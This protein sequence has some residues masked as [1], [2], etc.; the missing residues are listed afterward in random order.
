V[1]TTKQFQKK[2]K[3]VEVKLTPDQHEMVIRRAEK[4]GI[5]LATWMRVVLMQVARSQ[6]ANDGYIRIREPDRT[7]V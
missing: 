6:P 2:S 3:K 1:A 5:R 4:S 7:T